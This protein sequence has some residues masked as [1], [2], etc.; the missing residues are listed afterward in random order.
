MCG[1]VKPISEYRFKAKRGEKRYISRRCAP[2]ENAWARD[3]RPSPERRAAWKAQSKAKDPLLFHIKERIASWRK[4]S[5]EMGIPSDLT[6]DYLAALWE[7]QD[8]LCYYTAAPMVLH[9]GAGH[10]RPMPESAS[11][12]R[13]DPTHGYVIGNVVW[14]TYRANTAKGNLTADQYYEYI[15]NVLN[16]RKT[17][18]A[19]S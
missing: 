19:T 17:R 18:A 1:E 7:E 3:H 5:S 15:E 8:G 13:L 14:A 12:D 2:C 6:T 16:V 4:R 10:N 9:G 11:L